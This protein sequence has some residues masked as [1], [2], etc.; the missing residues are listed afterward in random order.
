MRHSD[1]DGPVECGA[2]GQHG[3]VSGST[4]GAEYNDQYRVSALGAIFREGKFANNK[5][6]HSDAATYWALM[7]DWGVSLE[8]IKPDGS[9]DPEVERAN[10]AAFRRRSKDIMAELLKRAKQAAGK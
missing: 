7:G 5:I 4:G 2:I 6:D 3:I 10:E 8:D 1:S 9:N